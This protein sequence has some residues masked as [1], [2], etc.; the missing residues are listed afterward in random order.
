MHYLVVVLLL[1]PVQEVDQYMAVRQP[2]MGHQEQAIR[3]SVANQVDIGP[4]L[5]VV[6]LVDVLAFAVAVVHLGQH[7]M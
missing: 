2:R 1:L 5:L 4:N 6:E 7:E 3:S